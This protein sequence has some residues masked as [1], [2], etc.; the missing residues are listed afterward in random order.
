MSDQ[1]HPNPHVHN[2]LR[3]YLHALG[4]AAR[5]ALHDLEHVAATEGVEL[6]D[7][8]AQS[9]AKVGTVAL[10]HLSAGPLTMDKTQAPDLNV[11]GGAFLDIGSLFPDII[12]AAGDVV[13]DIIR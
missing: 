12:K 11:P 13:G 3:R 10:E 1:L 7:H 2:A 8:A 4:D 5:N 6:A 9:L